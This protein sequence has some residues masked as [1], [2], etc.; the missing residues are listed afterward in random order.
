MEAVVTLVHS[1]TDMT[2]TR[3]P[4]MQE[5]IDWVRQREEDIHSTTGHTVFDA[6]HQVEEEDFV[7][8]GVEF[9]WCTIR[10]LPELENEEVN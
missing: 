3:W 8:Y 5:A 7:Q 6:E 9:H 4:T 1:S 10:M 2:V